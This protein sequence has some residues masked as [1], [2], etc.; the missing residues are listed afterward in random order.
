[1]PFLSRLY[2]WQFLFENQEAEGQGQ[3]LLCISTHPFQ[4]RVSSP[5]PEITRVSSTSSHSEETFFSLEVSFPTSYRMVSATLQPADQI[6]AKKPS[7]ASSL[8]NVRTPAPMSCLFGQIGQ[9][10]TRREKDNIYQRYVIAQNTKLGRDHQKWPCWLH[11]TQQNHHV[12]LAP[13]EKAH[14]KLSVGAAKRMFLRGTEIE[15]PKTLLIMRRR[16]C[17]HV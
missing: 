10:K 5:N 14:G 4:Q 7:R 1:M 17:F 11:H 8:I 6:T 12:S 16:R 3:L 13:L 2:T 9:I 15:A